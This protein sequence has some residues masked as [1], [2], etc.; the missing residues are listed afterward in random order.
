MD[1]GV[2]GSFSSSSRVA[3]A[4]VHL[5]RKGQHEGQRREVSGSCPGVMSVAVIK[6]P[7]K[8]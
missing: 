5:R 7:D 1:R 2:Q 8:Q 6:Y 4:G 3:G